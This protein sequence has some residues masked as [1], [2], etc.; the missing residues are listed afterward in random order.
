MENYQ[1]FLAVF[2]AE[3]RHLYAFM[4]EATREKFET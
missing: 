4:T 2:Q 1:T 3:P